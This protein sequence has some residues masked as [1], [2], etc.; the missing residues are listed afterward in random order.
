MPLKRSILVNH[1]SPLKDVNTFKPLL[2][3]GAYVAYSDLPDMFKSFVKLN[4]L[5][6]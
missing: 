4:I 1:P 2:L 6:L 3:N 5:L